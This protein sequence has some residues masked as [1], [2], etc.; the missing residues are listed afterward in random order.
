MF[1]QYLKKKLLGLKLI[2]LKRQIYLRKKNY[3][4]WITDSSNRPKHRFI[5]EH[6]CVLFKENVINEIV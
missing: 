4:D 6:S 3:L 1:N 2:C 5:Q